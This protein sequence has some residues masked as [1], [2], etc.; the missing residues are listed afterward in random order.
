MKQPSPQLSDLLK[1]LNLHWHLRHL[2]KKKTDR[3]TYHLNQEVKLFV[4]VFIKTHQYHV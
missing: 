2:K 3:Q 1:A 4:E